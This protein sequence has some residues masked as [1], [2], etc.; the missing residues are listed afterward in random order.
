MFRSCRNERILADVWRRAHKLAHVLYAWRR[1]GA[2]RRSFDFVCARAIIARSRRTRWKETGGR[3]ARSRRAQA[4]SSFPCLGSLSWRWRCSR[5]ATRRE[6]ISSPR[7]KS[8]RSQTTTL[9][10]RASIPTRP[11]HTSHRI[12]RQTRARLRQAR[13]PEQDP[14]VAAGLSRRQAVEQQESGRDERA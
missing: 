13:R 12:R 4:S 3:C 2:G 7:Q 14:T 6:G 1:R 10:G 9:L 8:R 5:L 11:N